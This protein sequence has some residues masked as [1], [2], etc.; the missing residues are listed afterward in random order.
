MAPESSAAPSPLAANPFP[1]Y[2]VSSL[3]DI[4]EDILDKTVFSEAVI[5][6][7]GAVKGH[8]ARAAAGV[9]TGLAIPVRGDYGTGK[10]HL[11]LFAQARLRQ[12]WQDG[13]DGVTVLSAPATEVPFP[14]WYLT[15]VAPLLARLN[16]PRMFARVLATVACEVADQVRL[17]AG[18]AARIR[19]DPLEVYPVLK[20]GL[21][22]RT[23]VER[24]LARVMATIAPRGSEELR[25]VLAALAWPQ[26]QEAAMHWLEG[27]PLE[28]SQR[29]QLG[30]ARDLDADAEA[31]AVL[32]A[33][34]GAAAYGG[35]LFA[36][37]VDE[38][39][40]LMA[41]DQRTDTQRNATAVKRLLEGLLGMGALV[42]VAG[43]WRAWEQLPDF[44]ARFAGQ[45]PV[46]LVTLTGKEIGQL[47][48]GYAPEWGRRLDEAALEAVAEAGGRNIRR[49]LAVLHQLYADT[50]DGTGPIGPV[51]AEAAADA[52]RRVTSETGR[53][54][55]VIEEAV[56]SEGG[57]VVRNEEL[58]G[59]L[60]FD[61]VAWKDDEIRLV[62]DIRHAATAAELTQLLDDFS[63]TVDT[64][65]RR[66][67]GGRG[68]LV[69]T[70]AVD[71]EA[72]GLLRPLPWMDALPGEGLGWTSALRGA[73]RVAMNAAPVEEV[74]K[75]DRALA[76][77]VDARERIR[78]VRAT[79]AE[80]AAVTRV[81]LD[82]IDFGPDERSVA[83]AAMT[84][85]A[86]PQ[87]VHSVYGADAEVLD[88]FSR[89]MQEQTPSALSVMLAPA[90][91]PILALTGLAGV[92]L[93]ALLTGSERL[94]FMLRTFGLPSGEATEGMLLLILF[95]ITLYAVV[96]LSHSY[97]IERR[98]FV[99]YQRW[100]RQVLQELL[101]WRVSPGELARITNRLIDAPDAAGGFR[102]AI[103]RAA[104][105][106]PPEMREEFAEHTSGKLRRADHESPRAA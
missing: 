100:G 77:Q 29:E 61:L 27:R 73:A 11:L 104:Q 63:I 105:A 98:A 101:V 80:E 21:L 68:L 56:R 64:L 92:L 84:R 48:A 30:V 5:A 96:V 45:P 17:T 31:A 83:A 41:E 22:S 67:P 40:H 85:A 49:V 33:V 60:R 23:D 55:A 26:R 14:A 99:R 24:E 89:S 44:K 97:Q 2:P 35:G 66:H 4:V 10:T 47:V 79:H 19:A 34:A 43:H 106:L 20:E 36:L 74:R 53:P 50:A 39:E 6:L 65:R 70:G 3:R 72:L 37:M 8:V 46:D 58:F 12:T 59:R 81:R 32:I 87:A 86:A 16:L 54:D 15:V 76:E 13:A 94:W 78:E 62:A 38:F 91:L 71:H 88:S 9:R 82:E 90:R 1:V 51:A 103:R 93:L 69:V 25:D 95:F 75:D 52:R 7:D 28:P 18:A 102:F 42:L 57:R